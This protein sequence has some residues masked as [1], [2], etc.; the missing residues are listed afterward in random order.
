MALIYNERAIGGLRL[1]QG[2][3]QLAARAAHE[4]FK[5]TSLVPWRP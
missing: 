3:F 4:E 5:V 2:K 1:R